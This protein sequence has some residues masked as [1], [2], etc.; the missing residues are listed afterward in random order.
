MNRPRRPS[1]FPQRRRP[2]GPPRGGRPGGP[3]A[4]RRRSPL[5]NVPAGAEP[6]FKV[7]GTDIDRQALLA[8]A[9]LMELAVIQLASREI[10]DA[11]QK[12][13]GRFDDFWQQSPAMLAQAHK[14]D[15]VL[16]RIQE[17]K[18]KS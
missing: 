16:A 14:L 15:E 7:L 4:P 18:G 2:S 17:R 1:H 5:D 12:F 9:D 11:F 8:S 3:Q 10:E 6:P 13:H